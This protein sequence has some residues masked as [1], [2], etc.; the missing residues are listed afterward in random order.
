[1]A[2]NL[3]TAVAEFFGVGEFRSRQAPL[4]VFL[5]R[6]CSMGGEVRNKW[7]VSKAAQNKFNPKKFIPDIIVAQSSVDSEE[8]FTTWA[9]QNGVS[10]Q[11]A[12]AISLM[13][14]QDSQEAHHKTN[15]R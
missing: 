9:S 13:I 5:E 11:S 7:S 10:P 1:M 8:C 15:Q 2:F 12:A 6:D 4:S 14:E 3:A